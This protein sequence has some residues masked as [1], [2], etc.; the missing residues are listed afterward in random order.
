MPAKPI[1]SFRL[2]PEAMKQLEDIRK[3]HNRSQ[4]NMIEVLIQN[5][6]ARVSRLEKVLT[7]EA[8]EEIKN[9]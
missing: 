5:E 8:L 1:R 6:F 3:F 4:S 2:S 7:V 9:G